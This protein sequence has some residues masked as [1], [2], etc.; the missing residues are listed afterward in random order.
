[1][2]RLPVNKDIARKGDTVIVHYSLF[3]VHY[4]LSEALQSVF[5]EPVPLFILGGVIVIIIV[6]DDLIFLMG[7]VYL[8]IQVTHERE[9][10]LGVGEFERDGIIL[11]G[12]FL[13]TGAV[14]VGRKKLRL[15]ALF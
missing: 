10:C 9:L 7:I 2:R 3:I 6:V 13:L 4:S 8:L 15:A 14:L 1:M 11:H 12:I 5:S